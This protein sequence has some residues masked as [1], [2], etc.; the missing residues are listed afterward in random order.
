MSDEKKNTEQLDAKHKVKTPE[1]P[2]INVSSKKEPKSYKLVA[3]LA[4]RQFGR[5]ELKS[6]GNA[7]ESVVKLAESLVRNKFAVFEKIESS[8]AELE[9]A[10]SETGTRQGVSFIVTLKKSD[11]FD[12]LTKDL[13]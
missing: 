2:Q 7:S 11:Q 4:L 12:E 9:D 1:S 8:V 5:V 6:L 3:K 13:E 10:N